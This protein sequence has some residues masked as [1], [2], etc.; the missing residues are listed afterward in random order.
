MSLAEENK[1]IL[2]RQAILTVYREQKVEIASAINRTFP[3][4]ELLRDH[5]FISE[6]LFE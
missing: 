4:L 3:F 2:F 6:R 1:L 5:G